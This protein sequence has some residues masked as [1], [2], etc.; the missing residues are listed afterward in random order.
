M[1]VAP[2]T[3]AWLPPV[4]V[5]PAPLFCSAPKP[6]W[7]WEGC[8]PW[9]LLLFTFSITPKTLCPTSAPSQHKASVLLVGSK[10]SSF[11]MFETQLH[12][13]TKLKERAHCDDK[14]PLFV[15]AFSRAFSSLGAGSHHTAAIF[16]QCEIW[17]CFSGAGRKNYQS[18]NLFWRG[19]WFVLRTVTLWRA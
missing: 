18:N 2:L 7:L 19:L 13:C 4:P 8:A 12:S 11:E 10:Q 16:S 14:S 17:L 5:L 15:I 3:P 1:L 9:P 6:Q